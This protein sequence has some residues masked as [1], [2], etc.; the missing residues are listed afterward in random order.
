MLCFD[1]MLVIQMQLI[2]DINAQLHPDN[3]LFYGIS[4]DIMFFVSSFG[5]CCCYAVS[6]ADLSLQ[7]AIK[8]NLENSTFGEI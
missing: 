7:G 6:T 3:W 2:K 4:N 5:G 1:N 8:S